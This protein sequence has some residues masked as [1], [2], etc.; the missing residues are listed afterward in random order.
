MAAR[1]DKSRSRS[2]TRRILAFPAQTN[3]GLGLDDSP[4]D[5]IVVQHWTR[6]ARHNRRISIGSSRSRP[7]SANALARGRT[8]RLPQTERNDI[9]WAGQSAAEPLEASRS[10]S[11]MRYRSRSSSVSV[12]AVRQ[13]ERHYNARFERP[14][15]RSRSRSRG[16]NLGDS[17][18][19]RL[20]SVMAA[21]V[22][23]TAYAGLYERAK[24]THCAAVEDDS[25]AVSNGGDVDANVAATTDSDAD[26]DDGLF[27]IPIK[28]SSVDRPPRPTLSTAE[29]ILFSYVSDDSDSEKIVHQP[30]LIKSNAKQPRPLT[31]TSGG[32]SY[33][34]D[35]QSPKSPASYSPGG[36]PQQRA[37]TKTPTYILE[38]WLLDHLD[39]PHPSKADIQA[40][41]LGTGLTAGQVRK[42][43]TPLTHPISPDCLDA[44][45][46][47][48]SKSRSKNTSPPPFSRTNRTNRTPG[49]TTPKLTT[50]TTTTMTATITIP[51]RNLM[52]LPR[53]LKAGP[54][55]SR[56]KRSLLMRGDHS[57]RS[58]YPAETR[59]GLA[60]TLFHC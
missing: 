34:S 1:I 28:K 45:M 30:T 19:R 27:A 55:T 12:V 25:A 11:R 13:A 26:S 37:F 8:S 15:H 57:S 22:R 54:R 5:D 35:Q 21:G 33:D 53:T 47:L 46:C 44:D 36:R 4:L 29:D 18:D 60:T 17:E 41:A 20:R 14:K 40:L 52:P 10:R 16:P 31:R 9:V 42:H 32:I 51:S 38:E 7:A 50:T 49:S 2:R 24:L 6:T 59:Q 48:R 58:T 39:D 56:P 3:D 43:P 23:G